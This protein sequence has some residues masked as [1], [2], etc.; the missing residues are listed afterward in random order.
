MKAL[1]LPWINVISNDKFG[2]HISEVGSSYNWCENSRENKITPWSND[3]V[4]DP[5]N[6]ALYITD[7]ELNE[8]FTIT[9][10]PIRDGGEYIIEHGFG[11]S[12]FNHTAYSIKGEMTVFSPLNEKL[13]TLQG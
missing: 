2:F 12:T 13:K 4:V 8:V 11:Y 1:Q 5:I 9:P 10:M 6:E 3:W 7:K